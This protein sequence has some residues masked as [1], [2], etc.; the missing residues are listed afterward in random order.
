MPSVDRVLQGYF[1]ALH[2]RERPRAL[3]PSRDGGST[4]PEDRE[5]EQ[6]RYT[7]AVALLGSLERRGD[8]TPLHLAVL[9]AHYL[10]LSPLHAL[11]L[12]RGGS[13]VRHDVAEGETVGQGV[14]GHAGWDASDLQSG[15]DWEGVAQMCGLETGDEARAVF[16]RARDV[17]AAELRR[18]EEKVNV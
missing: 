6:A 2:R 11:L 13:T 7:Y 15:C 9:R 5:H 14:K 12:K 17:V 8:L 1:N 18:R 3:D 16:N 4:S 10:C